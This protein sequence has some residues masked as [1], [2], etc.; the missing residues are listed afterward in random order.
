MEI[1]GLS[2]FI[3]VFSLV[4]LAVPGFILAKL[5]MLPQSATE[6]FSTFVLY[7]SQTL[8]IFMSF[9][10]SYYSKEIGLNMVYCAVLTA[11]IYILMAGLLLLVVKNKNHDAK[12]DCVRYASIFSNSGFMGIPFLQALYPTNQEVIIYAGAVLAVFNILNWTLGI[13][14]ITG[15]RKEISIKKIVTN[16]VIIGLVLGFALFII[17]KKPMTEVAPD[18]SNLNQFITKIFES[19]NSI[20]NTV[21][22]LSM[23]V[24]G[25]RLAHVELKQLFLDKWAYI[26]AFLKLFVMSF[27]TII[28]V[29]WLPIPEQVKYVLFFLNSM[30]TAA[31]ATL[32]AVKFNRDSKSSSVFVLLSTILSI[33]SLTVMFMLFKLII[34]S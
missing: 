12:K 31:S 8:L 25:M 3:A 11:V 4:L 18:N 15:D 1:T 16:P 33:V 19:L 32:F 17:V 23:A 26:T 24:I 5:K 14:L 28:L 30:P 10:K 9:Q 29:A 13:F 2:V 34:G 21:T 6:A 20:A 7:I 22:P 27:L